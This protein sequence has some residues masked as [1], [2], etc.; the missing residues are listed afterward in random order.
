MPVLCCVVLLPSV[1]LGVPH[2]D[3]AD[4]PTNDDEH[5]TLGN[6]G[7]PPVWL[8]GNLLDVLRMS[9]PKAAQSWRKQYGPVFKVMLRCCPAATCFRSNQQVFAKGQKFVVMR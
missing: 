4:W 9:F 1:G 7:P 8:I 3:Q 6:A 5:R 2:D